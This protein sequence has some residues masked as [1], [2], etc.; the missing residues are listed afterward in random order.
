MTLGLPFACYLAAFLCN[1]VSGCPAPAV[2]HLSSFSFEKLAK[3][4]AWP[5]VMGLTN[6]S[7]MLA[8][9]GWYSLSF[10]LFAAL[11]ATEVEG[12]ELNSGG[13]LKYKFNGMMRFLPTAISLL[14]SSL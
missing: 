1:D 10:V 7:A 5:G 6:N 9:L 8:L 3:D 13:R 12:I 2:L 4:V 14:I 11:P